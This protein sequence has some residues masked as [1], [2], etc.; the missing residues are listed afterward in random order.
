MVSGVLK[1]LPEDTKMEA[2]I[3]VM[4]SEAIKT[5]EIEGEFLSREDVMSSIR[6]DL[7]LNRLHEQVIDKRSKGIGELMGRKDVQI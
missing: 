1:S 6:N 7:G 4:V 5:S 2:I 3:D